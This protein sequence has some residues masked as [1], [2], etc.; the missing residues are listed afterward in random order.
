LECILQ[1][2]NQT[3]PGVPSINV[4]EVI[5]TTCWYIWWIRSRRVQNEEV[6]LLSNARYLF[7]RLSPTRQRL[8]S[9]LVSRGILSGLTSTTVCKTKC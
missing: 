7:C 4:K 1:D 5:V 2:Q 6:P 3:M 9:S 8:I